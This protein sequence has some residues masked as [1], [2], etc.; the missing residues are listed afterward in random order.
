MSQVYFFFSRRAHGS[1]RPLPQLTVL[2]DE[3][4]TDDVK[5]S[6]QELSF[7]DAE[8]TEHNK[9]R[10]K[11]FRQIHSLELKC[12]SHSLYQTHKPF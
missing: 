4:K 10:G 1:K 9:S 7:D 3:V 5:N 12:F 11:T 6:L 8:R 2:V